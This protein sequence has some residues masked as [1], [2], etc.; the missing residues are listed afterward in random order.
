ML[1]DA[2]C[3]NA[4]CPAD[5]N[6]VRFTDSGGLYLEVSPNGS[7]RWFLKYRIAGVEKSWRWVVTQ[8]FP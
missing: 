1:T 8:M 2:K 7:K 4:V 3:R 5:K 6:R